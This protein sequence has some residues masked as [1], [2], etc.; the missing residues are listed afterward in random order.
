[1]KELFSVIIGAAIIVAGAPAANAQ[2]T[3]DDARAKVQAQTEALRA[4]MAA[5]NG[6]GNSL[7]KEDTVSWDGNNYLVTEMPGTRAGHRVSFTGPEGQALVLVNDQNKITM[8]MSPPNGVA[9]GKDYK[10]GIEQVWAAYLDK[11][12]QAAATETATTSTVKTAPS[13]TPPTPAV[14]FPAGGGAI[15]HNTAF[16]D[17][18]LNSDGTSASGPVQT[19]TSPITKETM[20]RQLVAVYKGGDDPGSAGS[21]AGHV[22]AGTGT[23]ILQADNPYAVSHIDTRGKDVWKLSES[24]N[25]KKPVDLT[26]TGDYLVG[27]VYNPK[28]PNQGGFS[29]IRGFLQAVLGAE[30]AASD[31]A[32]ARRAKGEKVDFNADTPAG[33]NAVKELQRFIAK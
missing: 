9:N 5:R 26:T 16:G 30:K 21:K 1:M 23:A 19:I 17:I 10:P 6:N 12:S 25:G 28:D 11:K 27:S 7:V 4:Q 3:Q 14:E 31:E 13:P 22:L 20:T 32:T 15:V 2:S 29:Q 18:V 8:Y 33:Q 24:K